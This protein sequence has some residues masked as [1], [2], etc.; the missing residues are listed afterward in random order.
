[1]ETTLDVVQTSGS[2]ETLHFQRTEG[3]VHSLEGTLDN[4]SIAIRGHTVLKRKLC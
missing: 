3:V 1:M 2:E 4:A